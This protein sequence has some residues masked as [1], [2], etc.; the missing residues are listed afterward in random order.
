[1]LTRPTAGSDMLKLVRSIRFNSPSGAA[2]FV[3]GCSVSGNREWRVAGSGVTLGE[4][5]RKR[6]ASGRGMHPV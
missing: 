1:M 5:L 2:Q 4:W 6:R 3:A